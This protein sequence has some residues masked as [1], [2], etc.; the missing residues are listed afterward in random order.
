MNT[1]Q[2]IF[3]P[4]HKNIQLSPLI[5][6][7]LNTPEM[8]RL[9]DVKQLGATYFVFPS[10]NHSRLEHS[11]GVCHLAGIMGKNLQKKHP[12]LDITDRFIELLKISGLIHDIG[13]GPLQ[14]FI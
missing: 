10:A 4:L 9:R 7:I 8:Q 3:C 5:C 12:E 13:H 6:S 2:R 11:L 14:S 1:T